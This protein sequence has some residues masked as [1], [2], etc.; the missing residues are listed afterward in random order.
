MHWCNPDITYVSKIVV[1]TRC[2]PITQGTG[3]FIGIIKASSKSLLH[4]TSGDCY[5]CQRPPRSFC[6]SIFST[7]DQPEPA[8]V[9]F[10]FR[11]CEVA[12]LRTGLNDRIDEAWLRCLLSRRPPRIP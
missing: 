4:L 3:R 6:M 10:E 1:V 5:V 12:N 2:P 7:C 9:L 11:Q 8:N